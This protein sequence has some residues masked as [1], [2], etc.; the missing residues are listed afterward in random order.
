MV[1]GVAVGTKLIALPAA[2]VAAVLVAARA[3]ARAWGRFTGT[4]FAV[5]TVLTVPVLVADPGAFVENVVR[6]P[7]GLADVSSPAASPLPGHLLASTGPTGTILAFALLE[8]AALA[9]TGWLL[10]RPPHTGADALLR[11][12]VGL[13]AFTM[14]TPTTRFGYLV[15][16]SVLLGTMWVFRD[17]AT[18]APS[19]TAEPGS[20]TTP[21]RAPLTSS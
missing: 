2:V 13:G 15:Y 3:G 7:A 1:L 20:D 18:A 12:A 21:G 19:G 5:T 6:F 16:V 11:I 14:L 4:W 8:T 9:V 17:R 10:Y